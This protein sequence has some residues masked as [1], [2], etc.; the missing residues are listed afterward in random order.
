[1]EQ[2]CQFKSLAPTHHVTN[3]YGKEQ[4]KQTPHPL[5]LPTAAQNQRLWIKPLSLLLVLSPKP[6]S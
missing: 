1:M 5:A 6:V 2:R 4:A 3:I